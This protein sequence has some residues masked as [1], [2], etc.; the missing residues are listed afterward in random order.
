M[1]SDGQIIRQ[2][3]IERKKVRV[4]RSSQFFDLLQLVPLSQNP[5]KVKALHFI[6]YNH[7]QATN[8]R[9]PSGRGEA[10]EGIKDFSIDRDLFLNHK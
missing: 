10:K 7:D 5:Q 9:N 3:D 1:A 4:K 8:C 6:T 2:A